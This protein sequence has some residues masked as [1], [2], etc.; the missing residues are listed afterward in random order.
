MAG[1]GQLFQ[2][3]HG[4]Q[5]RPHGAEIRHGVAA[6]VP[7]LDGVQERH[8]VDAVDP[9][10]LQVVQLAADTLEVAGE[11]VDVQHHA[12]QIPVLVPFGLCFPG[13]IPGLEGGAAH[14]CEAVHLVA[15]FGE[16]GAVV[17]QFHIQPAQLVVVAGQSFTE[18][19]VFLFGH[20]TIPSFLI[21][22]AALP[23][24]PGFLFR[25]HPGA[26]RCSIL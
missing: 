1:V 17:I 10:L 15:Q 20:F 4:A 18:K 2:V 12:Q 6:V 26:G 16:H 8:Q 9:G 22:P 23:A 25:P 3:F 13:R 19:G 14:L 5:V 11:V 21:I 7:A 24:G